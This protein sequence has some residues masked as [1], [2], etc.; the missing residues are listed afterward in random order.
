MGQRLVEQEQRRTLV[1]SVGA[2]RWRSRRR[3][4]HDVLHA[5]KT[6]A[7]SVS[8]AMMRVGRRPQSQRVRDGDGVRSATV[9]QH[10]RRERV[11]R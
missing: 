1:S 6:E 3:A 10:R 8:A 4:S 2:R 5:G 7:A 9:S 11:A